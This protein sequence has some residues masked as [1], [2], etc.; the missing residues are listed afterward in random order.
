MKLTY[1]TI[2]GNIKTVDVEERTRKY[3]NGGVYYKDINND[4]IYTLGRGSIR[5]Q[6][7]FAR[8]SRD[9]GDFVSLTKEEK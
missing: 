3:R 2:R 9:A 1:R 7:V 5:V 4:S 6:G 8:D